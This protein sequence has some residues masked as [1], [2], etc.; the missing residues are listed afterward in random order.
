MHYQQYAVSDTDCSVGAG[1][2]PTWWY[3][4][5]PIPLAKWHQMLGFCITTVSSSF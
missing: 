2:E 1:S 5:S 3:L 4:G